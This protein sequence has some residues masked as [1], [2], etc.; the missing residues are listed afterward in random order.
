MP[1]ITLTTDFGL[2]DGYLGTMRG[3]ILSIA[4]DAR[5]VDL[6]HQIP[7]QDLWAGAFILYQVVPFFP[8]ETIHTV[9]IDPGVGSERRA[10]A[11]RTSSGIFVAA[12]VRSRF[13]SSF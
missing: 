13:L 1:I 10:L 9:V 2:T 5:L 7:A 8:P 11:V 6:S 4:P 12:C 3:V